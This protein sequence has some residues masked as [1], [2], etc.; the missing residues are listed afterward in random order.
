MEKMAAGCDMVRECLTRSMRW[1][2]AREPEAVHAEVLSRMLCR[3][4]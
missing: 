3:L 4:E 1:R 2:R